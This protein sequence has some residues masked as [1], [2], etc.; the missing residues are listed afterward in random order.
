MLLYP[1]KTVKIQSLQEYIQ[2]WQ[3]PDFHT[4]QVQPFL[5]L[6]LATFA[7]VGAS[8]RRLALTDFLLVSGFAYLGF[9]AARNIALFAIAA[10]PVLTRYAAPVLEAMN[11]KLGIRISSEKTTPPRLKII[12]VALLILLLIVLI[13]KVSLVLPAEVNDSYIKKISPTGA[14]QFLK[15]NHPGG[16][17]FNS[18]NQGGY[19]IW[20]LPEY[21][22]FIDPRTDLYND[23]LIQLWLKV[24]RVLNLVGSRF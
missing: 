12:N 14:V 16:N 19:L 1:L 21:P 24:M 17:L 5:V 20:A 4:P 6:L 8:R 18:Y 22:V 3:S 23:E 11:K 9:L 10:P 7:A 2:E 13:G 15:E